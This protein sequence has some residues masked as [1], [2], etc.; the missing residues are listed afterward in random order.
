MFEAFVQEN[1]YTIIHADCI[2]HMPEM[3]PASMDVAIFSPPFPSLYA[4][5]SENADL[6]NSEDLNGDARWHLK[7]FYCQLAR[8][9][10]PGRVVMVHVMQI[11]RMKRG[12]GE[13]GL[14]DFRGMNIAIGEAAGLIYD[15]DWLVRKNPQAQAIK[16]KAWELKFEGLETDR[17]ISRG[18]LADYLIKFRA[19][20]TNAVPVDS[21]DDVSRNNWIEWAESSW[22][23]IRET[24]TLN[25]RA[26]GDDPG[27][28]GENDVKHICL[29][30]GSLVLTRDGHKPI[31][32][33]CLGDMVLTHRGRWRPVTVVQCNGIKAIVKTEAQGVGQLF[34]TPEHR[35]W[36]RNCIGRGGKGLEPGSMEPCRHRHNARTATPEWMQACDAKGS[37]I[38]LK[39]PPIEESPL[40][41]KE[42]WLIGRWLGD[43]HF[44]VRGNLHISCAHKEAPELIAAMGERAGAQQRHPSTV[45]LTLKDRE[46]RLRSLL[47]RCGR[48][49]AGKKLPVEAL[50]LDH[51]KSEAL[52]SG[53]LSADG[54]FVE[55]YQRWTASSV[56]RPLLLGMAMVAQRAR[57]VVASVYAGRPPG[58][59]TIE[60]RTMQTQQDWI[61]SIPP[62]NVSAMLL[63]DGAWKKVRHVEPA[64]KAEV[65]DI[66]VAEDESFTVEGCIVHNC[67]LQLSVI[68][69]LV[70]LYSNP[71]EVVFSPFAGIGS[72][73]FVAIKEGRRFYGVELKK[74]YFERSIL[75]LNRAIAQR[76]ESQ[77][78]LFDG[79]EA[80]NAV[81]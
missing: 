9:M 2:R 66:Q 4:Y 81:R 52:L 72:E 7:A 26:K 27:T 60:G 48:S 41:T 70:R 49:C 73:G 30:R 22:M 45:Q 54:H 50:A 14:Y 46:G 8:I 65:W 6:G 78:S 71:G 18:A 11:P 67:P 39:L 32:D 33:V 17:T 69:R 37:Y 20:G 68:K 24:E 28:K 29:A 35:L 63:D 77:K 55:Q 25:V 23:D 57:G 56:S 19:P 80:T 12:G 31:E 44:D 10:K 64:G 47:K 76:K 16:G 74:E 38:N 79:L 36:A 62:Q 1:D 58:V 3:E 51:E 40:T 5:T 43:G 42:W 21:R 34:T 61:L 59:C 15:Y 13:G 53:Y 75:N